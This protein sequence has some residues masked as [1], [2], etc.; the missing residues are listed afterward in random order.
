MDTPTFQKGRCLDC[1]EP[2][3]AGQILCPKHYYPGPD[4]AVALRDVTI[5]EMKEGEVG[6]TEEYAVFETDSKLYL[7]GTAKITPQSEGYKTMRVEL[8]RNTFEIDRLTIDRDDIYVGWP[9]M[10]GDPD[11]F[12]AKLVPEN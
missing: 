4:K 7:I 1:D 5:A 2:I 8:K 11:F 6:Y 12:E 10:D 9:D 3:S